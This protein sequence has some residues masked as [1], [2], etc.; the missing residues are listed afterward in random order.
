M[1]WQNKLIA[2]LFYERIRVH[3]DLLS[4]HDLERELCESIG[5]ALR[6]AGVADRDKAA[7][8]RHY[9][10]D[11]WRRF[12]QDLCA[13]LEGADRDCPLCAAPLPAAAPG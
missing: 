3:V 6:E 4:L 9:L 11:A 1:E 8:T 13:E 7:L 2:E 10:E 5:R 12:E